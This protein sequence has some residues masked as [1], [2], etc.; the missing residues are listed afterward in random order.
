[1]PSMLVTRRGSHAWSLCL[2]FVQYKNM[3]FMF[4]TLS[5]AQNSMGSLNAACDVRATPTNPASEKRPSMSVTSATFQHF[6]GPYI[7]S[8]VLLSSQ[9]RATASRSVAFV[10]TGDV[11]SRRHSSS[12]ALCPFTTASAAAATRS[13][14]GAR[15]PI[16][17]TPWGSHGHRFAGSP[18]AIDLGAAS[19]LECQ[20]TNYFAES[21]ASMP[22]YTC[23]ARNGHSRLLAA[24]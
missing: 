1:M 7:L 2:K 16:I 12:M 17:S 19:K 24:F 9:N 22:E 5:T 23:R 20:Y 8:A 3:T 11:I 21:H 18:D 14:I 15:A 4:V 6:I 10:K 13:R